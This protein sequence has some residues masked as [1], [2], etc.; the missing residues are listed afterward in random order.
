V[1]IEVSKHTTSQ[2]EGVCRYCGKSFLR[3]GEQGSLASYFF[4]FPFPQV[5]KDPI[6]N[7]NTES[8]EKVQMAS[9]RLPENTIMKK[10]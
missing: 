7:V 2:I 4:L 6:M 9:W 5:D 10:M 8:S 1:R 3:P